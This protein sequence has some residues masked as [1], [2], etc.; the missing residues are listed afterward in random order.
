MRIL[1]K[2][3][4]YKGVG[5]GQIVSTDLAAGVKINGNKEHTILDKTVSRNFNSGNDVLLKGRVL[6]LISLNEIKPIN[7]AEI[8]V[9]SDVYECSD[10]T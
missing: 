8:R 1:I 10:W 3:Y 5:T 4:P 2:A 9:R 7:G 6:Q